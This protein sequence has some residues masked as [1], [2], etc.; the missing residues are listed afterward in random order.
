MRPDTFEDPALPFIFAIVLDDGSELQ[1]P[2]QTHPSALFSHP[3]GA[4]GLSSLTRVGPGFGQLSR[5]G[6]PSSVEFSEG[7]DRRLEIVLNDAPALRGT[8]IG[9]HATLV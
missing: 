6:V 4:T 9:A 8:A 2:S 7:L 3:C 5:E 1:P